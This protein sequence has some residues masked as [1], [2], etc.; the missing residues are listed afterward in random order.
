MATPQSD[1][2]SNATE[3]AERVLV[4]GHKGFIG[5]AVF[6]YFKENGL[7]VDGFDLGDDFPERRHGLM[8]HMAARTS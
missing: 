6:G 1:A 8:A 4:T 7:D 2:G 5:S 3:G